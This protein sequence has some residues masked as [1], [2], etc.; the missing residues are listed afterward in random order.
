MPRRTNAQASNFQRISRR[1]IS[2]DQRDTMHRRY[3]I[4][5]ITQGHNKLAAP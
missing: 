5:I 4:A 3:V 1:D 2:A